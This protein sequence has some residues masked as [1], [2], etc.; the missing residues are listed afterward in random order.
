M[1]E[2]LTI[3]RIDSNQAEE[4]AIMFL[5]QHHSILNVEKPILKDNLWIVDVVIS[6]SGKKKRIEIDAQTGNILAWK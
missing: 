5:Q 6:V 1:E 2:A 4:I 3:T